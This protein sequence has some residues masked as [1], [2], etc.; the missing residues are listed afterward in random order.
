MEVYHKTLFRSRHTF[1][2]FHCFLVGGEGFLAQLLHW[3]SIAI[4]TRFRWTF[5]QLL[6]NFDICVPVVIPD[7]FDFGE[8]K[9]S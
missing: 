6:Q 9:T 5:T 1:R 7:F 4:K 3:R 2:K 8:K